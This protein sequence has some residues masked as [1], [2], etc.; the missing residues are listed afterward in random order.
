LPIRKGEDP[1]IP[2][3]QRIR[4]HR[5][6]LLVGLLIW[7]MV[8]G[9]VWF[10]RGLP[11]FE[12]GAPGPRF[13]PAVLAFFLSLFNILYWGETFLSRSEKKLSFPRFSELIRPASFFLIGLLMIFLWERLGVVVTV[14]V[15]SIIELKL[16]EDYSWAR[17]I[18][19]GLVLSISTLLLFQVVLGIP[20]PTGP[21]EWLASL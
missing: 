3:K 7:G 20:L 19:V 17:S 10:T 4:G 14:L 15:A 6:Q 5:A 2:L 12:E 1:M 9:L 13:M 8:A 18:L 16:I 11:Y 21:F